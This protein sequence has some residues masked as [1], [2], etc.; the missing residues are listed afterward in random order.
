MHEE[1]ALAHVR[2]DAG[3]KVFPERV[4]VRAFPLR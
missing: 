3:G 1:G 4:G 2:T